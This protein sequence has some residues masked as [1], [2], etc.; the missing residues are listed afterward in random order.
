MT[1][2]R[3]PHRHT[4]PTEPATDAERVYRARR[5]IVI[6]G[7]IL[8]I[9]IAV[10][11]ALVSLTW[12]PELPDP[13]AMHWGSGGP[14]GFG[15]AAIMIALPAGIILAFAIFAVVTS[16]K[17]TADGR[18]L[19]GQ[20]L[21]IVTSLWLSA[22][23]SVTMGGSLFIQRGLSDASQAGDVGPWMLGG[24][25]LGTALAAGAWF[26]LPPVTRVPLATESAPLPVAPTERVAWSRT[27]TIAPAAW[28]AIGVGLA[29]ALAGV[30]VTA[31]MGTAW[32]LALIAFVVIAL[33]VVGTVAWRATADGRGLTVRSAVGWP[34]FTV[35]VAEIVS[36][37]AVHVD[38]VA[39]FGGWGFRW[40]GAGRSGVIVRSG[41][42]I[43][44]ERTSGKRFVVTVPDAATAASVLS[45]HIR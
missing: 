1:D 7:G 17:L 25:A 37:R 8:P 24:L 11:T 35:P 5:R 39:E 34:S 44:V 2:P 15:H 12:L 10:V 29:A 31:I 45:G 36:V 6:V 28:W 38:A 21:L 3:E 13:V 27:I 14:D 20:R 4:D 26:L 9:V 16:W 40:D 33:F 41:D 32:V 43:E 23:L 18:L 19:A 22:L 42:A 30:V